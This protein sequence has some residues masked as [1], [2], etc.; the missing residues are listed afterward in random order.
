[1]D[2]SL[3]RK[4][5]ITSTPRLPGLPRL[6]ASAELGPNSPIGRY[7]ISQLHDCFE[8]LEKALITYLKVPQGGF[9]AGSQQA[10]SPNQ[11]VD[12]RYLPGKGV[13]YIFADNSAAV[14]TIFDPKPAPGQFYAR[15][16][17]NT[18]TKFLLL[19]NLNAFI[20]FLSQRSK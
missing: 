14:G 6:P 9:Q 7:S 16:T 3:T 13:C 11:V 8:I 19:Q 17:H 2:S 1:M 12:E 20:H 5:P 4:E 15:V 18:L 10:A